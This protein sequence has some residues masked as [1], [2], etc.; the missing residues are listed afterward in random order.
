MTRYLILALFAVAISVVPASAQKR[1]ALTFDD[2]PRERGAFLDPDDRTRRL[3]AALDAAGVAQ[4]AFFVNP[5]NLSTADGRGGEARLAAY[6]AAGHVLADHSFS[7][8]HLSLMGADA[9]LADIDRAERWLKGRPGYRPWFRYPF[10]DEGSADR[11]K[12][13]AVRAGL[14]ARGLS[15]GYVTADGSDW[16]LEALTKSAA[17]AGQAMDMQALKR[18]Y[19]AMMVEGVE[20]HDANARRVFGRSP[21]H[22]MLMHETDLAALFLP[23]FVAALRAKGWQ[24]VP[25]DAAYADPIVGMVPDPTNANGTLQGQIA[26]QKRITGLAWPKLSEAATAARLFREQVLTPVRK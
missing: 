23:D 12:R 19:V 7:H 11:A 22:V 24:I 26:D 6:V 14:R 8:P 13:N 9:Y 16:Q 15:N 17:A 5:G 4:A 25:V 2:A 21:A 18:L 10:L 3:I 1:I 20:V